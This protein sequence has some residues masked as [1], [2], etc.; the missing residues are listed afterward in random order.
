MERSRF[1]RELEFV[2]SLCNPEY[3][4]FLY[5]EDYFKDDKFLA[6]LKYLSYWEDERYKRF[7]IYP[8][9]LEILKLCYNDQ[10]L[11]VLSDENTYMILSE[12]IYNTWN[13]EEK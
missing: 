1:E 3:L 4:R 7:L 12:Q 8:Q 9:C 2:Q 5:Q 11:E 6:F 13:I 10:F